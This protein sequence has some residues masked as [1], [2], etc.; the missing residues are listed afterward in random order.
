MTCVFSVVP[1]FFGCILT[2][3]KHTGSCVS[4]VARGGQGGNQPLAETL[5]PSCLPNEITLCTEVCGE[6]PF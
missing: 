1:A 6:L 5:P 3:L 2:I 4:G